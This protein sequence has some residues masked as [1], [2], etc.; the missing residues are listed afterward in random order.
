VNEKA[1]I[2]WRRGSGVIPTVA[3]FQQEMHEAES[4]YMKAYDRFIDLGRLWHRDRRLRRNAD[5]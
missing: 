5:A 3:Q 1:A 4:V 2:L